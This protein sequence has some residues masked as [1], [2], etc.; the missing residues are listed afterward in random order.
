MLENE[1]KTR[2]HIGS[3]ITNLERENQD[4]SNN[5]HVEQKKVKKTAQVKKIAE[6]NVDALQ[7]NMTDLHK[8]IGKYIIQN[9]TVI[10]PNNIMFSITWII[11]L[12]KLNFKTNQIL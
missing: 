10:F 11:I 4:L 2:S 1:I 8:D 9:Y 5:L 12:N 7:Q 6:A 3:R